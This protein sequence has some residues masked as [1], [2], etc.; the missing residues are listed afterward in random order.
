M[1]WDVKT[2]IPSS[3]KLI[4]LG[5]DWLVEEIRGISG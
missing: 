2:G 3:E 5:L 4:E 1:S